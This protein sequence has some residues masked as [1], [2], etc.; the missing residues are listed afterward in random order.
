MANKPFSVKYHDCIQE[1]CNTIN[2][3][4][5]PSFMIVEMLD[6]ILAEAKR[7]AKSDYQRDLEQYQQQIKAETD[8]QE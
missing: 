4:A 2:S 1:I 6:N 5:L 3:Y 7:V 8:K